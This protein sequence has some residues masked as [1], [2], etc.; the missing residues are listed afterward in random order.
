MISLYK[1]ILKIIQIKKIKFTLS[2]IF[3]INT[4]EYNNLESN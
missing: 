1:N 4:I 2:N 3:C